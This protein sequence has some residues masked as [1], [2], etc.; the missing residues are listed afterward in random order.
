MASAFGFNKQ[1]QAPSPDPRQVG[2]ALGQSPGPGRRTPQN[3][4]GSR[5][6][7]GYKADGSGMVW[8]EG[9]GGRMPTWGEAGAVGLASLVANLRAL[10][11][12][13]AR[14]THGAGQT[15]TGSAPAGQPNYPTDDG[16]HHSALNAAVGA[17]LTRMGNGLMAPPDMTETRAASRRD[18]LLRLGVTEFEAELLSQSGGI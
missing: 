6:P 4:T 3:P 5:Q 15:G 2:Q 16:E 8:D 7:I 1:P 18:D 9:D 12:R 14:F 11:E 10:R 13:A 17:A